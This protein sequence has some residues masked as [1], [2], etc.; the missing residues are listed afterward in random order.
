M[1]DM[2]GLIKSLFIFVAKCKARGPSRHQV[3]RS[4]STPSSAA[5]SLNPPRAN[6]STKGT[7]LPIQAKALQ[8]DQRKIREDPQLNSQARHHHH[9]TLL[10]TQLKDGK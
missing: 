10:P 1:I 9:R 7:P 8:S 4:P 2:K 6:L 3:S 5:T